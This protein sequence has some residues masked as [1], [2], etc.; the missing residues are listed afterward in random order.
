MSPLEKFAMKQHLTQEL[1]KTAKLRMSDIEDHLDVIL[2]KKHHDE[3]RRKIDER[4]SKSFSLRHPV[5]TG[6]PTLGIAPAI[7]KR[8]ATAHVARHLLRSHEGIRKAH[9]RARHDRRQEAVEAERLSIERARAEAPVRAVGAA[10][11]GATPLLAAYLQAKHGR[12]PD[13]Q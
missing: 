12:K 1:V 6:I 10:A 13:A 7:A 3:T 8:K 4:H 11:A 9:E 5:L 2:D